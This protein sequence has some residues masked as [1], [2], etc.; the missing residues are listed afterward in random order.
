MERCET[1]RLVLMALKPAQAEIACAYHLRNRAFLREWEPARDE[2]FYTLERQRELLSEDARRM[3]ERS[4]VRFWIFKRGE[5]DRTIG[6]IAFSNIV[7]GDFLS[8]F[9]GYKLD[10]AE[11]NRGYMTEA[12]RAGLGLMFREYGLHRVEANIM[13]RNARSLRV[14]EKLGFVNEGKSPR[15]LRINGVWEDH[16]H[17]VLLNEVDGARGL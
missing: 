7:W 4:A 3:E 1:E 17:M 11:I 16:I 2:A 14:A 10:E 15:Y 6:T 8:C 5:G 12:L 9:L 13:P